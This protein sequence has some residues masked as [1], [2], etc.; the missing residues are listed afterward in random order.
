MSMPKAERSPFG[1]RRRHGLAEIR[2]SASETS[3]P[4]SSR[5]ISMTTM[6]SPGSAFKIAPKC[7]YYHKGFWMC[8][9]GITTWKQSSK[10]QLSVDFEVYVLFATPVLGCGWPLGPTRFS[11]SSICWSS[12]RIEDRATSNSLYPYACFHNVP[13]RFALRSVARTY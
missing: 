6:A 9:A 3:D 12:K 7:S 10:L 2:G 4:R 8:H 1:G 11:W 13:A 5:Q